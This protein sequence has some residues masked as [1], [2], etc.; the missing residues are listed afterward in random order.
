MVFLKIALGYKV[1]IQLKEEGNCEGKP[2]DL[3]IFREVSYN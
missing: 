2:S 1:L 3:E